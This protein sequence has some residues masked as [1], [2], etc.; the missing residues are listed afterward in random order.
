MFRYLDHNF[1][2]IFLPKSQLSF[3]DNF[4]YFRVAKEDH[5]TGITSTVFCWE[6]QHSAWVKA[7]FFIGYIFLQVTL[8]HNYNLLKPKS[9]LCHCLQVPGGRLSEIY[10][11][12]VVLG[13]ATLASTL[14]TMFNPMAAKI[15]V[16]LLILTRMAIG[17]AQGVVFPSINPMMIK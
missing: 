11:T 3:L 9:K 4:K 7:S 17:L 15:D 12:K 1:Y 8:N 2:F 10:G 6:P 5:T 13:I 16:L 14:L